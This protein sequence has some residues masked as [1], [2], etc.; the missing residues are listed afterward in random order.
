MLTTLSPL[1][2]KYKI[3]SIG[4]TPCWVTLISKGYLWGAVDM[5]CKVWDFAACFSLRGYKSRH[6]FY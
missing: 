5:R 6:L 4:S 3:R 2:E 1:L